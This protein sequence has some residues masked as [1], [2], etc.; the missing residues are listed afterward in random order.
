MIRDILET[1]DL[2]EKKPKEVYDYH[3]DKKLFQYKFHND[4]KIRKFGKSIFRAR[5]VASSHHVKVIT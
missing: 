1:F 4:K 2:F 5:T 3:E